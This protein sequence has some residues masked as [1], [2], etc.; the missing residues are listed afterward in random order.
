MVRPFQ[1][2]KSVFKD[3]TDPHSRFLQLVCAYTV[4]DIDAVLDSDLGQPFAAY[5]AQILPTR[6]A[7]AV[8]A[9]TIIAGFSMGQGCMVAASR[10]TFAYGRDGVFPFSKYWGRVNP[11]TKTPVNAVIINTV[12]GL[13]L[14]LLIFGGELAIGALFSIG[15][16]AQYVAFTIPI[17]I[18][19]FFVGNRFRAGP[20]NLGRLTLPIGGVACAFVLLMTPIMCFPEY[21]GANLE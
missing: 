17:A 6:I 7:L 1:I 2:L 19:L 11:I 4:A 14:L 18:R 15:A 12:I 10:V 3:N 13:L 8:L 9:I 16:I 5:V 20:W 21:R